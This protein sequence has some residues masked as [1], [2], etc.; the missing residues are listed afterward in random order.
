MRTL[1]LHSALAL[2]LG[3]IQAAHAAQKTPG[4]TRLDHILLWGRDIDQASAAMAVKLGFQVRPGRDPGGVANRFVRM[5]DGSYVELLGITRPDE[6][7]DPGMQADQASLK[8]G[9]GARS[10]G[11]RASALEQARVSLQKEG[12]APT[13]VFSASPND[14]DGA[15]PTAPPRWRLFAFER[16]PLSSGLF[17]IDYAPEQMTRIA[18]GEHPNGAQAMTALW[19]LSQDAEANRKQ[20][21]KMGYSG[22]KPMRSAPLAAHG[23]CVP[24][25]S[26]AV[27][28]LQPDGATGMAA[29]ALR[30]GGPQVLGIGIG[31]A[32][33]EAAKKR[34]ERGYETQLANYRGAQGEAFLAPTQADLGLLIEFH[35]SAPGAAACP[36]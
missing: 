7:M 35:Q 19:L 10:F 6:E 28:A 17:F 11:L 18:A 3:A 27:F 2:G 22:A 31:V 9:A 14:P 34:V 4:D 33:L 15:G 26:K 23:Y 12:F 8:G 36:P 30:S 29:D 32:D 20:F 13:P 1:L 5:P 16:Q 24:I 25:G 21:E